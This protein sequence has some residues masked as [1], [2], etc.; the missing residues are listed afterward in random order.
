M[1]D[2]QAR[3]YPTCVC[4]AFGRLFYGAEGRVY[5]SQVFIDDIG[6]LGKCYQMNDPTSSEISDILATDGGEIL[7]QNTG[8]MWSILPFSTGVLVFAERGVWFIGKP[9]VSFSALDYAIQ[10][11]SDEGIVGPKAATEA[12][13]AVYYAAGSGIHRVYRNENGQLQVDNLTEFNINRSIQPFLNQR[14][15]IVHNRNTKQAHVFDPTTN[16]EFVFEERTGGWYKNQFTGK[17]HDDILFVRG[18]GVQYM[19]CSSSY[20]S[21]TYGFSRKT[22][23]NFQDYGADYEA[24][25]QSQP[26]TLGKFSHDKRITSM[27]VFFEKTETT[28]NSYDTEKNEFV[29][30]YPSSC[31]FQAKWDFDGTGTGGRWTDKMDIYK[32]LQR[33]PFPDSY[34]YVFDTGEKIIS[35]RFTVRGYGKA[36][37]FRFEAEPQEDLRVLGYTVE[38]RMRG[39]Q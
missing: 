10:K 27:K 31:Q 6:V 26:E 7:I 18:S 2:R 32:P 17:T 39:K 37:Q 24:F 29:F 23:T 28:I 25:I 13:G 8:T 22:S 20:P 35:T 14:T 5:F 36:V 11:I 34:P 33:K 12:V 4:S 3:S 30:D 21:I 1:L 16:T 38:Y 9:D 15:R 19:Y